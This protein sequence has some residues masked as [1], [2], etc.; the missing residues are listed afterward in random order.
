[1]LVLASHASIPFLTG[2]YVGVDVF[3]V[4][5][6]FLIT[7]LLL[8]DAAKGSVSLTKFYSRRALRILPAAT[9]VIIATDIASAVILNPFRARQVLD[10]SLWASF[11]AANI[12]FG[13]DGTDYFS[14]ADTSPL[15]HFWSLAV[16]EQYYLIWPALL[17]LTVFVG[18]ALWA[19]LRGT[20]R[21]LRQRGPL[22]RGRI[23]A[24]LGVLFVASL[25]WSIQ[26]TAQEPTAA[27]FSTLTRA[28]ELILGAL[29]AVCVPYLGLLP[30]TVRAVLGWAGLAGIALA[31]VLFDETTPF[32]GSAALLPTVATAAVLA[33]G[34]L[35]P[36]YGANRL[37]ERQPLRFTGDISY[38][39]Y[40][41]HWP[42]LILGAAYAGHELRIRQNLLLVAV[43]F[44]L[45]TM[46]YYWI[47][48]P[49]RR[50]KVVGL[51]QQRRS[52]RLWPVA[53][54]SVVIVVAIG[55]AVLPSK[56]ATLERR[57]C[58]PRRRPVQRR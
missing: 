7:G 2:G 55:F 42:L 57:R 15:Q 40:L 17:A 11:F 28:W 26:Q 27:Y 14:Q 33:G 47:E 20:R 9:V 19:R 13:R 41:W 29:L 51:A 35:A 52:L 5:S 22:P 4:I 25:A 8:S 46:S 23:A 58:P 18:P 10:D 16:E 36:R 43:A 6:G 38:S 21:S 56:L 1:M 24:V 50:A 45:A 32:P 3:F 31:A 54:G 37:L 48:N 49:V 53:V 12:K 44:A 34:A 39:L 30:E